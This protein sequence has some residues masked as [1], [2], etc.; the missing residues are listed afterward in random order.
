M[1]RLIVKNIPNLITESQLKTIF[2]KKVKFLMLKL[3]LKEIR[4]E[5]SVLLG[6]KMNQMQSN[7]V[8]SYSRI[9]SI[10]KNSQKLR[11][12]NYKKG[13]KEQRR[14]RR[15]RNTQKYDKSKK[16]QEFLEL[17][18][19]NK[20]TNSEISWNDNVNK[21]VD[22]IF[23]KIEKEKPKIG[24]QPKSNTLTNVIYVTNIPYTST[25]QELRIAFKNMELSLVCKYQNKEEDHFLVFV[26][27]SINFQRKQLGHLM[28]QITKLFWEGRI[29]HFRPQFKDDK[30]EQLKQEQQLKQEK[31]IGEEKSSYKKFKKQQMLERL[32]D[33]T[34]WNTLFLNPNTIIEGICKKYSLDKKKILSEENDDMAVKMAQM[35]TQ[36]IKETKVWLKIVGLNIDFLIVKKN[37]CERSNIIIFVKNIQFRVYETD[38]NELFQ[39]MVKQTKY[40]LLQT[41]QL[42]LLLC[43]MISR[44]QMLLLIYKIINLQDQFYIQN[45]FQQLQWEK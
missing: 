28:N 29:F 31:M 10:Q 2:E 39:D 9:I 25:D 38:L 30:E 34:S 14:L 33:T 20:K 13:E 7:L 5:G 16:F 21:E 37:Q 11:I 19:T 36:V 18:K 1:S 4:I 22:E 42:E 35:E 24:Q 12:R 43:K 40:F 15:K 26:F 23:E 27:L 41:D 8:K 44:L 6:I 3:F 17:M 45:G 32:I